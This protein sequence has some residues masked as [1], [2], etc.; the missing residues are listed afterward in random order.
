MHAALTSDGE[1]LLMASDDPTADT[2]GPVQGMQ[3]N[4]DVTDVG[5]A[6][7]VFDALADGGKVTLPI[8]RRSGRRCSACASIVSARRG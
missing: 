3:V 8:A 6:K 2:F 4:Y 5:E 1:D 7:R